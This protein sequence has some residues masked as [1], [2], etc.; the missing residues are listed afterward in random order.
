[1][2]RRLRE[3]IAL[4]LSPSFREANSQEDP[5]FTVQVSPDTLLEISDKDLRKAKETT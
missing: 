1:M 5:K 4:A 2:L 3:M